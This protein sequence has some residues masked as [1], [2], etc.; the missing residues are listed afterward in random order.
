MTKKYIELILNN[1]IKHLGDIGTI[2]KVT[3]G[4]ARNYLLPTNQASIATTNKLKQ[5]QALQKQEIIFEKEKEKQFLLLQN[6]IERI[7]KFTLKRNSNTTGQIFGSV[8]EKDI[9]Q[10]M[11]KNTGQKIDKNHITLPEIK[12]IGEYLINIKLVDKIQTKIQLQILPDIK[13]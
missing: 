3:L 2:V 7:Y 1:K 8:S 4:Y 5:I 9:D 6:I 11:Y 12:C 13:F 10:L